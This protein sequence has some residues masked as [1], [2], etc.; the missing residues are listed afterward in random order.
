MRK[1]IKSLLF[2]SLLIGSLTLPSQISAK[3][4]DTNVH[5]T[6]YELNDETLFDRGGCRESSIYIRM[7][8]I[9]SKH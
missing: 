4:Y 6:D 7:E 9:Y 3:T 5:S 2:V 1:F 8:I